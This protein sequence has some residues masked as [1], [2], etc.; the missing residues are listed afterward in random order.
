MPVI[1]AGF[2][3]NAVLSQHKV[4]PLWDEL[5][6]QIADLIPNYPY[7]NAPDA[8]SAYCHEYSRVKL[9][10]ELTQILNVDSAQPGPVH[11]AFCS[12]PFNIVCTTNI[13]F[14]IEKA[15][16]LKP[17]AVYCRPVIDEDQL[18]VAISGSNVLLVK[19]HGDLHHPDRLVLTE[20]DYDNFISRYPL[21]ATYLG[22]LLITK[23]PLFIG[24]SLDDPDFRQIWQIIS[25]RLG[26]MRRPAYVITV[27]I[28]RIEAARYERRHVKV[29]NLPGN[30]RNYGK[31]L[32]AFFNDLRIYWSSRLIQKSTFTAK[33]PL[34]ELSLPTESITRLCFFAIPLSLYTFYK[35]FIFPIAEKI[36]L[37]PLTAD[38]VVSPGDN[39]IAKV[40]ALLD[41]AQIMIADAST[42]SVLAEIGM[43]LS[44]TH[45][46]SKILIIVEE[47]TQL[48]VEL[49]EIPYI[50]RP[51]DLTFPTRNFLDALEDSLQKFAEDLFPLLSDEPKRLL[52]KGEYA[53]AVISA[54]RLFEKIFRES[55]TINLNDTL[56]DK[57]KMRPLSLSEMMDFA[58]QVKLLTVDEIKT[59]Q[60]FIRMRNR[61]LHEGGSISPSQARKIVGEI[62]LIVSHLKQKFQFTER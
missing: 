5:G 4:M 55:I 9:I 13:D 53:A 62:S 26:Q 43:V 11:Q 34:D 15:Y 57:T 38:D 16:S 52:E 39:I 36:G 18:S 60:N 47:G 10:E 51:R 50:V 59:I 12:L 14:L 29:V 2:S 56:E 45:K 44:R 25:N 58:R 22:N 24:Y 61:L 40:S 41:R 19:F 42:P 30:A 7:S 28:N 49:R 33:E 46:G 32:E 54:T 8:L 31:I 48:P 21:L 37:V 3:R 20:E 27:G 6:K 17:Q 23:T 35:S 1:G